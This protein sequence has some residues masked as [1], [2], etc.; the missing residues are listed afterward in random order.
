M[1][2]RDRPNTEL[3]FGAE[4]N[5]VLTL[6]VPNV[7]LAKSKGDALGAAVL[8]SATLGLKSRISDS[9]VPCTNDGLSLL[10]L[11]LS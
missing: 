8:K 4:T 11:S 1:C 9:L 6:D 2:I 5:V 7:R 10:Y 3:S